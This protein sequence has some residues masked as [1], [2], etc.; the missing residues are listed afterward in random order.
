MP[1]V[2]AAWSVAACCGLYGLRHRFGELIS[3]ASTPVRRL[4]IITLAWCAVAILAISSPAARFP[5]NNDR[6]YF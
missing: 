1:A 6:A 2:F 5:Y 3:V 4:A